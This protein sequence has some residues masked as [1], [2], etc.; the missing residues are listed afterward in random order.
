MPHFIPP[1]PYIKWLINPINNWYESPSSL[2]SHGQY[3]YAETCECREQSSACQS[4]RHMF[5]HI[6]IRGHEAYTEIINR[7]F[8]NN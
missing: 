6:V 7:P 5:A 8:L 4:L 3:S 2:P 1:Q